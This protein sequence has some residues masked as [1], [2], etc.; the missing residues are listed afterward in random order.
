MASPQKKNGYTAVA[1]ELMEHLASLDIAASEFRVCL[2]ILRETYG[3]NRKEC[4]IKVTRIGNI[5]K[6]G[7]LSH[8]SRAL[9]NLICRKIVTKNGKLLSINKDWEKW[10]KKLPKM[11][12]QLTKNGN[13]DLPK[14]VTSES[15]VKQHLKQTLKQLPPTPKGNGKLKK[16]AEPISPQGQG[17]INQWKEIVGTNLIT[18]LPDQAKSALRLWSTHGDD[19]FEELLQVVRVI[20]ADDFANGYL[21]MGLVNYTGLE[22]NIEKVQAYMQ[23]KVDA[24]QLSKQP[25]MHIYD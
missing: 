14:M 1:N 23:G 8:T 24:H 16:L 13:N 9:S 18:K 22:K 3:F 17:F 2:V 11:V 20:R 25:K 6:I 7:N 4:A 12:T 10:Q 5:T 15:V 21:K 19:K